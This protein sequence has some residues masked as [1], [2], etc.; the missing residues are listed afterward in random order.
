MERLSHPGL[1]VSLI[2][3]LLVVSGGAAWGAVRLHDSGL[4][5]HWGVVGTAGLFAAAFSLLALVK[6]VRAVLG[7][8]SW[9][10]ASLWLGLGFFSLLVLVVVAEATRLGG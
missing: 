9:M 3:L 5:P 10:G 6:L 1:G 7:K 4:D 8:Q 2:A